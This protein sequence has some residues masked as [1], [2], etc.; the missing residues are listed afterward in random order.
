MIIY[1]SFAL[2]RKF[3]GA[4]VVEAEDP[5]AAII[6]T[7]ALGINPGGEAMAWDYSSVWNMADDPDRL[8]MDTLLSQEELRS[9]CGDENVVRIK[10]EDPEHSACIDA[11][12]VI[13]EKDNF[14][15]SYLV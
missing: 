15:L 12:I 4:C 3:L 14:N 1:I 10:E 13:H 8:P 2:P 7:H 5:S 11:S 9:R 6:K